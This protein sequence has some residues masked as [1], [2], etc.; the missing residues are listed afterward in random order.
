MIKY[1]YLWFAC[2]ITLL[3]L[4]NTLGF[5]E[6]QFVFLAQ[7]FIKGSFALINLPPTTADLSYF[8]NLYYWPLGPFPGI[9]LMPF[10]AIFGIAF[11]Q[12]YIQF[13]L[14]LLNAF[15]VF[16]IGKL[17][18]LTEKRAIILSAFFIF[19]SVYTPTSLFPFSWYF[20]HV[21]ATTLLLLSIYLHLTTKHRS[22]I[23]FL[24]GL[25]VLTRLTLIF[26][27][28]F[29]IFSI[30]KKPQK[31]KSLTLLLL[32]IFLFLLLNSFYNY[33]RFENI[34]ES[35]YSYQQVPEDA[36]KRRAEGIISLKHIP[37]NLYYMFLK[38]PDPVL[39]DGYHVFKFP[40]IV[41]DPYGISIF[42]MSPILILIVKAKLKDKLVK[43]GLLTTL[44]LLIPIT[45]YYGIGHIQVG[46]RY[47]LD[48]FP[49][50]LPALASA[51]S[52][53]N[54]YLLLTL[55]T[56]GIIM[57]WWLTLER[58]LWGF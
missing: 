20:A 31:L 19:G 48:F 18:N 49:L 32:P 36:Q 35:G 8:N 7:S 15:L 21:I 42:I 41:Y 23:G 52:R 5:Q 55:T 22:L 12:S 28:P 27:V 3:F 9:I 17:L 50:L 51:I 24:L 30:L 14:N 10:V 56:L 33:S 25:T 47:A 44:L 4:A 45:T 37:A 34:F 29:F 38:S 54:K 1:L 46:Y 6:Q 40:Y 43:E 2:F 39:K 26:S 13:P 57:T 11:H 16:K 58:F 53:T